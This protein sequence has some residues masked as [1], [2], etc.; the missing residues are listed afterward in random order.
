[1]NFIDNHDVP[2]F[3]WRNSDPRALRAALAYLLTE[4]GIPC[5]YYGTEQEFAGGN[6]PS[7]R[8]PLW[9]SEYRTDGETFRYVAQLNA[10][11]RRY[12]ALRRGSMSLT[13][14]TDR[15]GDESDAGIVGFERVSGASYALVVINAQGNHPSRT[16]F[17]G[18][19][20]ATTAAPGSVLADVLS[21]D[22]FTVA[23][24]GTLDVEVAPFAARILVPDAEF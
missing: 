2:R 7:N 8:E 20:M 24:D 3:L 22:R 10:A 19:A 9:W 17:E 1:M 18:V 21:G 14:T 4:D 13:W 5:L 16:A 15:V 6:D 12:E 23:P 11:R